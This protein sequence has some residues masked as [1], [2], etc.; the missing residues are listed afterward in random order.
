MLEVRAN[1]LTDDADSRK[2]A[3]WKTSMREGWFPKGG[4]LKAAL[5]YEIQQCEDGAQQERSAK[6]RLIGA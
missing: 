5:H 6:V 1:D 4:K 3:R 2:R